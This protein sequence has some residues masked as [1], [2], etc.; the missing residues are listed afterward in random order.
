MIKR[1]I[2]KSI[3]RLQSSTRLAMA[4]TRSTLPV[5]T[6]A[7]LA[8]LRQLM[9]KHSVSA[10]LIPSDDAHGLVTLSPVDQ[11]EFG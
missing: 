5:D 8:S 7:R 3:Q 10:Y 11:D 2:I 9:K 1:S 4:S 6:S